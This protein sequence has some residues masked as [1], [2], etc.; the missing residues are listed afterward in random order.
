MNRTDRLTAMLIHLQ[1]KRVVKAQE[2]ADR[3]G[4]SL[5]TVYRDVRALEE[6]GVPLGAE[7]GVGYFLEDYHLPPVHLT[8][9]EASALLFGG[10]LIE[11]WADASL[12]REF[13]SALYKIKA[14]LKRPDQEHLDDLAP[15]VRVFRPPTAPP[16][17]DGLLTDLQRALVQKR[18]LRLAYYSNYNEAD[19][20]REVEPMGLF[21]YGAGWHLL[22][23]CRLRQDFRDFRVERIRRLTVLSET[24]RR[25]PAALQEYLDRSYPRPES[26]RAVVVFQKSVTRFLQEQRYGHGFVDEEDL[27]HEVRMQFQTPSFEGLGR[28]LLTYTDSVR[29]ESP[30]ELKDWMQR[31]ALEVQ[32]AYLDDVPEPPPRRAYQFDFQPTASHS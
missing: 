17:A 3:F 1:T 12:R 20:E 19:T 7:A 16:L 26:Q 11:K 18:V 32:R 28:W 29:I 10:K 23:F 24:F 6:A 25:D 4:I 2:L 15:H 8:N 22:A 13:E 31:L 14:V 30:D 27:G 5:R 21:Q 9:A